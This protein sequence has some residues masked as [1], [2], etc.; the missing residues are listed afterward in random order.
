MKIVRN[1]QQRTVNVTVAELD[2]LRETEV[3]ETAPAE[4]AHTELGIQ[5]APITPAIA[6][7]LELPANRG[8]AFV[9]QV[10][11]RSPAQ[12]SGL[13]RGDVILAVNGTPVR[14]PDEVSNALEAM[15]S[16]ALLTVWRDGRQIGVM[17]R[18]RQ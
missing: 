1:R 12:L 14:N 6:R 4:G 16:S 5:L 3:E 8:G 13:V 15:S 17:L 10:A 7:Q 9:S 2:L 11:P 18:K